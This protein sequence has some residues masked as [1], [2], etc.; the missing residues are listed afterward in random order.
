MKY[1]K[2]GVACPGCASSDAFF[3]VDIFDDGTKND[4]VT[5]GKCFSCGA[6]FP[7]KKEKNEE[8]RLLSQLNKKKDI[9]EYS[10]N[11]EDLEK[12]TKC[13]TA[14]NLRIEL[15]KRFPKIKEF[16]DKYQVFSFKHND[17]IYTAFP[18]ISI[19]DEI[20]GIKCF[21][22]ATNCHTDFYFEGDKKRKK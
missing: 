21:S 13:P 9:E 4:D 6:F 16:F 20:K 19:R 5:V 14:D 11:K 10:H 8:L 22:F 7:P 2:K 17:I 3:P 15:Y 18:H 12:W 1:K